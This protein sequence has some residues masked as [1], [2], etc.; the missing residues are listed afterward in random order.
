[1]TGKS[2]SWVGGAALTSA[3]HADGAVAGAVAHP[4]R[5]T[6]DAG[7]A[8][9]RLMRVHAGSRLAVPLSIT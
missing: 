1:M 3:A 6:G 5:E 2:T 9:S 8:I 4:G 7:I